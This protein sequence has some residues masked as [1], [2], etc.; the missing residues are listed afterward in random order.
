MK[1]DGR[2]D[3]VDYDNMKE[4][5]FKKYVLPIKTNSFVSLAVNVESKNP[6]PNVFFNKKM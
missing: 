5:L 3:F 4:I 2:N 6:L 1:N